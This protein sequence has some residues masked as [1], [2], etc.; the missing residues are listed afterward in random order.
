MIRGLTAPPEKDA[1][2]AAH[3]DASER[4]DPNT[5][6]DLAD[7]DAVFLRLSVRPRVQ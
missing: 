1:W 6:G 5:S 7:P 4:A 3:F 2:L